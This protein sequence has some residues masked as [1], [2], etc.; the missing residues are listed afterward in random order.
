VTLLLAHES[1]VLADDGS[2]F[3]AREDPVTCHRPLLVFN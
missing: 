1:E 2:V 3:N